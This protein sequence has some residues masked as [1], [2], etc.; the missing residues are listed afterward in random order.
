MGLLGRNKEK[1]IVGTICPKCNME[2]SEPGR[3]LRHMAKAHPKKRKIECS[4]C[5]FRN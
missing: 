2:F 5:G 3:T 1:I 4:S